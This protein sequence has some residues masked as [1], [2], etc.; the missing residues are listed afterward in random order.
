MP[1]DEP[2]LNPSPTA[3]P[4]QMP[5]ALSLA[6]EI[7]KSLRGDKCEQILVLDVQ[8][9]SQV[10]DYIIIASGTSD[11]QMNSALSNAV[12]LAEARG[13]LALRTSKD[14]RSTWLLADLVDIVIHL[15]EPNT[16]AYY[17]LEMLWS[18]AQRVAWRRLGRLE[19]SPHAEPDHHA[20]PDAD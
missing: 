12:E 15:F 7:A 1:I 14:D 16:R 9:L 6:V 20:E 8:S 5:E 2:D 17:D 11:R 3:D 18:D 10:T 13:R 4:G 19:P